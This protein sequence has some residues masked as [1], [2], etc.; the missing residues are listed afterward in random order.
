[1]ADKMDSAVRNAYR[2]E[3]NEMSDEENYHWQ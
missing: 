3:F 2:T 1:M